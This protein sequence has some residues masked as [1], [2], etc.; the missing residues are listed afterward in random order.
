MNDISFTNTTYLWPIL[1]GAFLLWIV[2]LWK[3]WKGT[4]KVQFFFSAVVSFLAI[5]CLV[6]MVLQPT[7]PQSS[8]NKTAI[9]L[10]E[11]FSKSVYDSLKKKNR[12]ALIV[13]YRKEQQLKEKLSKVSRVFVLGNGLETYDLW[14]LK[15]IP[16]TFIS[17]KE[18]KGIGKLTYK[19]KLTLGDSIHIA[20]NYHAPTEGNQLFLVDPS[21]QELDSIKLNNEQKQ[22]FKLT[23]V[24][25][26][27]GDFAYSLVQKNSE[28]ETIEQHTLPLQILPKEALKVLILNGSPSFET[29]Y[30]KNYLA[31]MG[32]EVLV[33]TQ[34]SRGR[35]KTEY[36]NSETIQFNGISSSVLQEFDLLILD[37]T[38]WNTLSA[39]QRNIVK[40]AIV[41]DG[42]GLFMQASENVPLSFKDFSGIRFKQTN[43]TEIRIHPFE[44]VAA[45]TYANRF[46]ESMNLVGIHFS[47]GETIT[48][49]NRLGKGRIGTT[50]LKSTYNLLLKGNS[51]SYRFL[52]AP[53]IEKLSKQEEKAL[54]WEMDSFL[55]FKDEP[56][57]FSLD[58]EEEIPKVTYEGSQI[59]MRGDIFIKNRW[60]GI[61]YPKKTGWNS[62]K[63]ANDTSI[64]KQFFVFES[65]QWNT[66]KSIQTQGANKKYLSD[67][68]RVVQEQ[69]K[70][71]MSLFWF[72][73]I[74]IACLGYLWILPKMK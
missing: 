56:V 29:K 26:A 31:E 73:I 3:E 60:D 53:V 44:K 63:S 27:L 5:A 68:T 21:G 35:Y 74:F 24:S 40:N 12:K 11:G 67:K 15:T 18:P 72:Y 50:V 47:E 42:L 48:G 52:W 55:A 22:L 41:S 6:V 45:Y 69:V 10:T 23:S 61:V 65:G 16:S 70:E 46:V 38:L 66:L 1:L 17:G 28:G 25:K 19:N 36:L 34:I 8:S 32:N 64:T 54:H 2:F 37:E 13:D 9:V 58:T 59:P 7:K 39:A 43:R 33:R 71:P 57:T 51:D 30:L 49:Y 20:G 62:L 14:Q 4:F